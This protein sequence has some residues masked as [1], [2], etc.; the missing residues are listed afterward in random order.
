[1]NHVLIDSSSDVIIKLSADLKILEFNSEAAKF[2]GK[3]SVDTLNQYFINMFVPEP[4]R[5]KTE[6]DLNGM[7]KRL[8][9]GKFKM[10]VIAANGSVQVVEWSANVMSNNLKVATG[11]IIMIKK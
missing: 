9:G 4:V 1:M 8:T 5:K 10:Q 3:K 2:F 6:K 11:I 7:L